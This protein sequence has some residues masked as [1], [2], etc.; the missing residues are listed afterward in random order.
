MQQSQ[1]VLAEATQP[2]TLRFKQTKFPR[3]FVVLAGKTAIRFF[4]LGLSTDQIAVKKG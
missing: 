4:S 2:K 3:P 1:N